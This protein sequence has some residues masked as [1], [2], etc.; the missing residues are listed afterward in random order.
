MVSEQLDPILR[1][2]QLLI[3]IVSI[4]SL[5]LTF[6]VISLFEKYLSLIFIPPPHF[7]RTCEPFDVHFQRVFVER[8]NTVRSSFGWDGALPQS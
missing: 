3:V 2:Q 8:F 4:L 6:K 5:I 1:G 7:S